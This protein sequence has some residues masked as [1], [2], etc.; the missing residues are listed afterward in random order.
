MSFLGLEKPTASSDSEDDSDYIPSGEESDGDDASD[1]ENDA[2]IDDAGPSA[3]KK[4][5]RVRTEAKKTSRKRRGGIRLDGE[6]DDAALQEDR[7]SA[8]GDAQEDDVAASLAAEKKKN[9]ELWADF[10]RDVGP[11]PKKDAAPAPSTAP[12]PEKPSSSKSGASAETSKVKVLQSLEFAGE[13]ILVE[14][15]V[16]ANSKEAKSVAA[17]QDVFVRP[18]TPPLREKKEKKPGGALSVLN[19]LLNKKQKITTLEKSRLDWERFKQ[20]RGIGQELQTHNRGKDGYLEKQAF[21]ERTDQRQFEL[22]KAMR[23]KNRSQ[24]F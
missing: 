4:R 14:K 6:E 21:L 1:A 9:D 12:E 19:Q 5:K 11:R 18:K 16:A 24:P 23:A 17:L 15:E 22:E 2:A 8:T 7:S 10:L 3:T 20:E 13:T